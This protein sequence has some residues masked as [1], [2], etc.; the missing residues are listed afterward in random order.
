MDVGIWLRGLGLGQYESAFHE[1]EIE[2]DV[3]A[4][5]TDRRLKDLGV[6][7]GRRLKSLRAIRELPRR[8]TD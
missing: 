2:P 4:D 1:S 3:V 7:L 5:L 6:P 8:L